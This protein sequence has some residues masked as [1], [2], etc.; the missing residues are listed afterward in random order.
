MSVLYLL[1]SPDPVIEGTDAVFQ[2]VAI[3]RSAFGGETL[4]LF[5][6]KKPGSRFPRQLYGLH[7]MLEIRRLEQAC[8]LNHLY[9]PVLHFFP[10]LRFLRNPVVYTVAASL[11]RGQKPSAIERLKA[12]YRIV[13]SND[14]DAAVLESWGLSNFTVIPPGIDTSRIIPKRLAVNRDLNLLMA[15]APWTSEQFDLKGIDVLLEAVAKLPFLRLILLWRGLLLGELIER[16]ERHGVANRVEI[17]NRRVEVSDYLQRAHATVLLAKRNDI[18]KAYPHSLI[19]SL[20]ANKPVIVSNA[21]PMADYV[22]QHQCGIVLDDVC[23]D[24]LIP[25]IETLRSRYINLTRNAKLIGPGSFSVESMV[26]R[27]RELYGFQ[28]LV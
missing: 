17:V 15:S 23:L 4:N 12:L 6:R 18:V 21:V 28:Q 25:A 2:D 20:V 22:R 5:P 11:D 27:H 9:F 24:S 3:L 10:I 1:T 19:E 13:V 7:R 16:V 14:R 26:N 8:R